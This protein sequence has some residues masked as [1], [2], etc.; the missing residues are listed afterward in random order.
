[1]GSQ[2]IF[3]G[4]AYN[5]TSPP[6]QYNK[7][8]LPPPKGNK[9]EWKGK[10][11]FQREKEG[12]RIIKKSDPYF[13]KKWRPITAIFSSLFN[14]LEKNKESLWIFSFEYLICCWNTRF[15][16]IRFRVESNYR[17]LIM[18]GISKGGLLY[19]WIPGLWWVQWLRPIPV[20]LVGRGKDCVCTSPV[21][22]NQGVYIRLEC[23][24]HWLEGKGLCV[25]QSRST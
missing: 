6:P 24:W 1:M 20:F 17:L 10:K 8:Y 22:P 13:K 5:S 9:K 21:A 25:Y 7:S 4:S 3:D 23:R 2:S 11:K 16:L 14:I 12:K 15:E 19:I 18:L